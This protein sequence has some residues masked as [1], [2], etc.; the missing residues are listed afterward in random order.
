MSTSINRGEILLDAVDPA[1]VLDPGLL[2]QLVYDG[3]AVLHRIRLSGRGRLM[4][5]NGSWSV[6]F[7]G[8]GQKFPV[9]MEGPAPTEGI[10]TDLEAEILLPKGKG[11]FEPVLSVT[12]TR[13]PSSD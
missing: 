4:N 10:E 5:E 2:R 8:S 3:G 1:F 9:R 12:G 6:I 7:C 11:P 13:A